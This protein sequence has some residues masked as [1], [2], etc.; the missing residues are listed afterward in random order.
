[1]G[2][3]VIQVELSIC[4]LAIFTVMVAAITV[5]VSLLRS[6]NYKEMPVKICITLVLYVVISTIAMYAT[7]ETLVGESWH[8]VLDDNKTR[9]PI[10]ICV[11][12]W[13][14]IHWQFTSYYLSTAWLLRRTFR[15]NT[16]SDFARVNRCRIHLLALEYGGYV[17]FLLFLVFLFTD[18]MVSD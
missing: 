14:G 2:H 12:I 15:A 11:S 3:N 18:A 7:L 5:I 10:A 16:Q 9:I 17:F 1:M 4:V 6:G 8:H 13:Q